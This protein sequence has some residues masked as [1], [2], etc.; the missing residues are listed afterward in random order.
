M[1]VTC[2]GTLRPWSVSCL[3]KHSCEQSRLTNCLCTTFTLG[4]VF[5]SSS[6]QISF[7]NESLSA[8]SPPPWSLFIHIILFYCLCGFF[9]WD[10]LVW[11]YCLLY[12]HISDL[13]IYNCILNSG[14]IIAMNALRVVKYRLNIEPKQFWQQW[15][16]CAARKSGCLTQ[17]D[18]I[19][20]PWV[21]QA[22]SVCVCQLTLVFICITYNSNNDDVVLSITEI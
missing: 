22:R 9:H 11:F 20:L 21:Y 1:G 4:T 10:D 5:H 7:L 2:A 15:F 18:P 17:S 6:A 19:N 12:V 3:M 8:R 16:P 13:L 14:Q